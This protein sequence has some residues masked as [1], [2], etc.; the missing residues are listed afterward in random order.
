[1][2]RS[3]SKTLKDGIYVFVAKASLYESKHEKLSKD[4]VKV[5]QKSKAF[6]DV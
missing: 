1:L 2:F 4:F 6:N 3:H 5:L